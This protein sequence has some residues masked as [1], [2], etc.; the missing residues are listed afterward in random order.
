MTDSSLPFRRLSDCTTPGV[1]QKPEHG[2]DHEEQGSG[3]ESF[4][5][6]SRQCEAVV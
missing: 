6:A 2:H 3:A 5:S 1:M 4:D